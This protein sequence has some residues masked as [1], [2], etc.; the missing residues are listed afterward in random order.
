MIACKFVGTFRV[1]LLTVTSDRTLTTTELLRQPLTRLF[2][3]AFHDIEICVRLVE[4]GLGELADR[5]RKG[6]DSHCRQ[7]PSIVTVDNH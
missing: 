7:S 5:V 1:L 6:R 3:S 2:F 4:I